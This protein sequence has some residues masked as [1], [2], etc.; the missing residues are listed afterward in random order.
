MMENKAARA[1]FDTVSVDYSTTFFD[2]AEVYESVLS[3]GAVN[4]ETLLGMCTVEIELR[5]PS[6]ITSVLSLFIGC[7][8]IYQG[9]RSWSG[10]A[11]C[12]HICSIAMHEG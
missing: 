12:N 3:S 9:K 4:S 6:A 2:I 8:N 11:C 5:C 1:A 10:G 7:L